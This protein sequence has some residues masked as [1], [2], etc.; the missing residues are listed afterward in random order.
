MEDIQMLIKM[1]E[2][3][4]TEK[5]ALK[6]K[7]EIQRN[8]INRLL[9]ENKELLLKVREYENDEFERA[10]RLV[11][12]DSYHIY[13]NQEVEESVLSR[14]LQNKNLTAVSKIN[15]LEDYFNYSIPLM[16]IL[17]TIE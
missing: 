16:E 2:C 17:L 15:M 3:T 9:D 4:A 7:C 1:L 11:A 8:T 12:E 10:C 6:K 14:F 5:A 13:M